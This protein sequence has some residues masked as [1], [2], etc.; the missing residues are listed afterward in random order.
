MVSAMPAIGVHPHID[1]Y[2]VSYSFNREIQEHMRQQ[3]IITLILTVALGAAF[4]IQRL[5]F[6]VLRGHNAYYFLSI[7]WICGV[8]IAIFAIHMIWQWASGHRNSQPSETPA[9]WPNRRRSYRI[10]YPNFLRPVFIIEHVDNLAIRHLEY[11]VID[12]S[13]GGVCFMDDGSLGSAESL[14]GHILFGN[15]HRL[16]ISGKLLRRNRNHLS[17]ELTHPIGWPDI[18]KEQRRLIGILKPQK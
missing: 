3:F 18:L 4:A 8:L 6:P 15:G 11:P 14:N 12:L 10:I 1:G 2:H 17:V 7:F 5:F 16:G 9:V 13:Q